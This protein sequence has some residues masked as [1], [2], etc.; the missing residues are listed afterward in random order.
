ME[1]L[2]FAS[3]SHVLIILFS[4]VFPHAA[5]EPL[6]LLLPHFVLI[7]AVS[8]QYLGVHLRGMGFFDFLKKGFTSIVKGLDVMRALM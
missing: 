2:I 5:R 1:L 8:S 4:A 7:Q 6:T 3:L